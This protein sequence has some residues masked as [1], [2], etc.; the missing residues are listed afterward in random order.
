MPFTLLIAAFLALVLLI[1]R[2]AQTV[3]AM[4]TSLFTFLGIINGGLFFA[5]GLAPVMGFTRTAVPRDRALLALALAAVFAGAG[6]GLLF[7][8]VRRWLKRFFSA[9][10]DPGSLPQMAAL[11]LCL[12]LLA[13]TALSYVLSGGQAGLAEDFQGVRA[14][15]SVLSAVIFV[16]IAFAGVGY[17]FGRDLRGALQRLGLRAP[18]LEEISFGFLTGIGLVFCGYAVTVVWVLL[19]PRDTLQ[20][21]TQLSRLIAMSVNTV[22]LAAIVAA[23]AAIGEEIAF[24]GA[25]QPVV[26]LWPAA[27]F[28]ALTHI[29]YTLTPATV[30]IIIV[31]LGFG[32]VRRRFNTTAAII[33]HFTYDFA[34]LFVSLYANYLQDVLRK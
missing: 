24:R 13:N 4:R 21:Q 19:T 8:P 11:S 30:L 16:M 7:L 29:Q 18:N 1:A 31:G 3:P 34:L 25:L 2:R 28:F 5:Y 10:Y 22:S 32:V 33:A 15:D 20:D 17:P 14:S 12:L 26:G 9:A 23:S 27:I 6:V